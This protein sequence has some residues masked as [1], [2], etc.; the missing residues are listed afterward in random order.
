MPSPQRITALVQGGSVSTDADAVVPWWSFAKT[1]LAGAAL[2][3]VAEQRLRLD[4][5]L[6]GR[7]FTLRQ[8]L[9]HRAGL[10]CYGTLAAY[11]A[12]VAAGEAPWQAEAM[13]RQVD[14]DTLA[15]A[16][17]QGW[18]Y[19][20][21]GYLLVR[22]LVEELTGAALG[23]ALERLVFGPLGISGVTVAQAPEDLDATAWGNARRYHP[24]WVYHGLLVGPP[25]SAALLLHR[26]LGTDFLPS[27]L[28]AAMQLAHPLGGAI[29]GRP[30]QTA[31]YGLGLMIGQGEPAG[32][33]IGHTG[34]GPGSASA[35]YA[36]AGNGTE[37]PSRRTAAAFAAVDDPGLVEAQ[38]MRIAAGGSVRE[39]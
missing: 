34:G 11:H 19:S 38:A 2:A 13:L 7:P 10:R 22:T 35:V 9:Q 15:Y 29:P 39:G 23:P 8:L 36:L 33:Y 32:T 16:P 26:L 4:A 6:R 17:G 1:V 20:N 3:L 12:A 30:W 21:I 27:E 5:P 28:V 14:A 25:G 31:G 37:G 18:G 24:G